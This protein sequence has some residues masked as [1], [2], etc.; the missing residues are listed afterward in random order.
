MINK[1]RLGWIGASIAAGFFPTFQMSFAPE[2]L[3][4]PTGP[5]DHES[6]RATEQPVEALPGWASQS[7]DFTSSDGALSTAG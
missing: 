6:D 1:Q 5:Q 4:A 3:A 2:T 7:T